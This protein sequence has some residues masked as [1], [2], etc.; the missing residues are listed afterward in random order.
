MFFQPAPFLLDY[1]DLVVQKLIPVSWTMKTCTHTLESHCQ[2]VLAKETKCVY[3]HTHTHTHMHVRCMHAH[4]HMHTHIHTHSHAHTHSH[5]YSHTHTHSHT[6]S[7]T[8][9]H[10]HTHT[11]TYIHTHTHTHTLSVWLFGVAINHQLVS[12]TA[13]VGTRVFCFGN[14]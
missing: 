9:T 13:S 7:L 12:G 5:T 8:L 6:H 4:T 14:E 11:H 1:S 3:M 2:S 10:T